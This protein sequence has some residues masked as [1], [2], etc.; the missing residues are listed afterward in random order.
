MPKRSS[1]SSAYSIAHSV[2]PSWIAAF[3]PAP[4][5]IADVAPVPKKPATLTPKQLKK[6]LLALATADALVTVPE[7]T[8]NLLIFN[9]A[10]A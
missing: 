9:N 7:E 10:T 1:F 4:A 8:V 2:L 6:A 3:L 5:L